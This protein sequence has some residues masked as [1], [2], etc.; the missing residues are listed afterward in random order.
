MQRFTLPRDIY[1]GEGSLEALK[2]LRGYKRAMVVT[3]GSSMQRFGFLDKLTGILREADM[4]I[5]LF[6]GVEPD[7]SVD[8]VMRGAA[9]MQAFGPDLIVAIGGGSP[10]DAAKAMWVFYE[11]PHLT[12]D[13]IKP[14]FVLPEL[15]KKAKFVAI[16][17]TS[18]SSSEVSSYAVITD[19]DNR[20]K[21]PLSDFEITPDI[22]ILD[23]ALARTMPKSLVADTG[24][25][26]LCH[27]I[28]AFVAVRNSVFSDPLALHAITILMDDLLM[29]YHGDMS[30]RDRVHLAQCLSGMAFSNAQ[31]G[32]A[33]SLSHKVCAHFHLSQGRCN[34]VL[35]PYVICFNAKVCSTRYAAIARHL[36]LDGN[37]DTQLTHALVE[38]IQ[39]LCTALGIPSNFKACGVDENTFYEQ[40]NYIAQNA[41]EDPCTD[42]NPRDTTEEDLR[43]ILFYAY[44]GRIVAF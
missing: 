34:A 21:Y 7:P 28:E 24:M 20:I 18:G 12:L 23:P 26:S 39:A 19:Y 16:P 9:A 10:I 22:A 14:P 40:V 6:E 13:R 4:E 35:L 15:R 8:T 44:E 36:G 25:D 27:A 37:T 3:G 1:F 43:Q 31:L 5:A 32:I 38:K 41:Q 2:A 29:S 33:S 42:T 17:S 11:H 30:A